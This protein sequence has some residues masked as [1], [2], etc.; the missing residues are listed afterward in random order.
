M[1]FV[2]CPCDLILFS[3]LIHSSYKSGYFLLS[4]TR[5]G[6]FIFAVPVADEIGW[7]VYNSAYWCSYDFTLND[8]RETT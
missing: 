4:L 7:L 8:N 5:F 6:I 2:L 3:T 1:L